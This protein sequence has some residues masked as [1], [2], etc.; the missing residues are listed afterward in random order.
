MAEPEPRPSGSTT[1]SLDYHTTA[2]WVNPISCQ[3]EIFRGC[4]W[5]TFHGGSGG[6]MWDNGQH[7]VRCILQG[8]GEK[9]G[10]GGKIPTRNETASEW[11]PVSTYISQC[12]MKSRAGR[13]WGIGQFLFIYGFDFFFL[14]C[15]RK[16]ACNL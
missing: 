6:L 12:V 10:E 14:I 8:M 13:Q 2:W 7:F 3:T 1:W 5:M 16:R 4:V 15:Q 9:S 11:Y